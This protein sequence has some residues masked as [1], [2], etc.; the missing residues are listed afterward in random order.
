MKPKQ[1]LILLVPV[2]FLVSCM[3]SRKLERDG[4]ILGSNRIRIDNDQIP[5]DELEGFIKQRPNQRLFGIF[6][7]RTFVYERSKWKWLRETFGEKP[8]ILDTTMANT[9]VRQMELYMAAKGYFH[10]QVSKEVEFQRRTADVTYLI[11]AGKPYRI[12]NI[13]YL[14]SDNQLRDLILADTAASYIKRGAVFDTYKLDDE[15]FRITTYLRNLGY[16]Y[17]TRDYIIYRVDSNLNLRQKDITLEIRNPL[18]HDRTTGAVTEQMH[19]RYKINNIYFNTDFRG[20]MDEHLHTDT[21]FVPQFPD[22]SLKQHQFAYIYNEKLRMHPQ[23]LN[24]SMFLRGGQWYNL[25]KSNLSFNRLSNL[26]ITRF[27]NIQFKPAGIKPHYGYGLLDTY[28]QIARNPTQVFA[29]ETEGTNTGGFLGIGSNLVYSNR[30]LLQGGELF[31]LKLKG[32]LEMQQALGEDAPFFL[33]FNTIETGVEAR[34]ELPQLWA[35]VRQHRFAQH[36]MPRTTLIAGLNYQQRPDYTRLI[37]N[38]SFGY[39]WRA[40]A[41]ERHVL[42]PLELNSVRIFRSPEFTDWLNSLTDPRLINQYTDHLVP[43][44]RYVYIFNN[45]PERMDRNFLFF[46]TA[47]ESSGGLIN[48]AHRL[49]NTPMHNNDFHSLFGIRYAQYVRFEG[50]FRYYLVFTPSNQIVYRIAGGIGKPY[51]NSDALPVEK[52]FYA[53]GAN[54]MRGWHIRQLGPGSFNDP[55]N[56][57]EKMGELWLETNLEYRFPIYS[58]LN[59]AL[60]LDAGNIWLLRDNPD[61]PG[62]L[63]SWQSFANQIAVSSGIGLRVDLGFF[64]FRLDSGIKLK[65]PSRPLGTRWTSFSDFRLGD[66]ALQF[67]IGY[68]F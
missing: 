26:D 16:F 9:S 41:N 30:N 6:R 28:V 13:D 17:F 15:R 61:F 31:S 59:G 36:A 10:S 19:L 37:A 56:R 67:G 21:L 54:S 14:I 65:D 68:P 66:I 18:H 39:E 51:G 5:A 29:I 62:G 50:D 58:F 23:L 43:L 12:R 25:E 57:F 35:P 1:L 8:V 44:L 33:G 2:F 34:L 24:R 55:A 22:D 53:G 60:F 38:L 64:I 40:N 20:V 11:K 27:V 49:L 4:Y 32:A 42:I 48:A 46:R 47:L 7:F 52:G 63:F 45:Q 3:P